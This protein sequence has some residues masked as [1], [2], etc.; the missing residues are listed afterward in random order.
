MTHF[1]IIQQNSSTLLPSYTPLP[2]ISAAA[3]TV[4]SVP[5]AQQRQ[6]THH[7]RTNSQRFLRP[8]RITVA[9]TIS[10]RTS[11]WSRSTSRR[12]PLS[13]TTTMAT[14][15]AAVRPLLLRTAAEAPAQGAQARSQISSVRHRPGGHGLRVAA[16]LLVV[17][18]MVR[19]ALGVI[20]GAWRGAVVLGRVKARTTR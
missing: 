7:S 20:R 15:L 18:V 12:P 16:Y 10:R 19:G 17:V 2:S 1:L 5:T 3:T 14:A 11:T 9:M 13:T 6:P 8:T 4:H